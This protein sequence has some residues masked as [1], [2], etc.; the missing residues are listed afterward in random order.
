MG[1][2][3]EINFINL[4]IEFDSNMAFADCPWC[5]VQVYLYRDTCTLHQK[6]LF[7]RCLLCD[8]IHEQRM[9]SISRD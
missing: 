2:Y 9:F 3:Q 7:G 4:P 1:M 6:L 8:F 5:K